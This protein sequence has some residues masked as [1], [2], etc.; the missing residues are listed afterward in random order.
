MNDTEQIVN[1][2]DTVMY[3]PEI[4][5]TVKT[6]TSTDV[7][8]AETIVDETVEQTVEQS[9][10]DTHMFDTI[11]T[12]EDTTLKKRGRPLGSKNK[13]RSQTETQIDFNFDAVSVMIDFAESLI[14]SRIDD[15]RC[16]LT[17]TERKVIEQGIRDMMSRMESSTVTKITTW[18]SPIS[19]IAVA[20]AWL[21]RCYTV[22]QEKRPQSNNPTEPVIEH[23]SSPTTATPSTNG[24]S[25]YP[26]NYD[27]QSIWEKQNIWPAM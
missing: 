26:T 24:V 3:Q 23:S 6:D 17:K 11:F 9:E 4:V 27:N 10:S 12:V 21:L 14:T 2:I 7:S 13:I 16:Y 25:P 22:W 20:G 18:M 8:E 1:E 15:P 19:L 5:E